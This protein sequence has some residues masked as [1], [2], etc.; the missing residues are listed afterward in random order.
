MHTLKLNLMEHGRATEWLAASVLL[1]F[2]LILA[3]PGETTTSTSGFTTFVQ[4]GLD[5]A[6]L[7]APLGLLATGRMAALYING[8]W[9][10]SPAVRMVGSVAGA[11]VFA[12]I[13][14]AFLWPTFES[15][16]AVSTGSV[17]FTLALFDALSAYR[18]GADVRMVQQLTNRA[19]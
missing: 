9:K 2:A 16:S 1:T 15:A 4:L 13:G 18:S 11:G 14:M 3:I 5:D 10:R 19:R 12:M 8:A 17:Y 6:A 7:A